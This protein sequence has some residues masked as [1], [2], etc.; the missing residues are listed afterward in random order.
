MPSAR[1]VSAWLSSA[2]LCFRT[3]TL[4]TVQRPQHV[5]QTVLVDGSQQTAHWMPHSPPLPPA[6]THHPLMLPYCPQALPL[7]QT[8]WRQ[9][10]RV[11][12]GTGA[13]CWGRTTSSRGAATG[14]GVAVG[15]VATSSTATSGNGGWLAVSQRG[16]L[17]VSGSGS[18][19]AHHI[20]KQGRRQGQKWHACTGMFIATQTA[21][22]WWAFPCGEDHLGC[23]CGR[24]APVPF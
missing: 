16:V 4:N 20:V 17:H 18:L 1:C 21:G 22:C 13:S 3:I 12:T 15:A 5:T 7:T 23:M 6:H 8:Q 19:F 11:S 10:S 9:P 14:K 24:P 2:G